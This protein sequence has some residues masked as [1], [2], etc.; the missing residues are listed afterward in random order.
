MSQRL[1]GCSGVPTEKDPVLELPREATSV[2]DSG[3]VAKAKWM[4][5]VGETAFVSRKSGTKVEARVSVRPSINVFALN[6]TL[7]DFA[8][9]NSGACDAAEAMFPLINM[10]PTSVPANPIIE[11]RIPI[12]LSTYA[13]SSSALTCAYAP[14]PH[15][16]HLTADAINQARAISIPQQRP[17]LCSRVVTAECQLMLKYLLEIRTYDLPTS[18]IRAALLHHDSSAAARVCIKTGRK[19]ETAFCD[20]LRRTRMRRVFS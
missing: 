6:N 9:V 1:G 20:S 14:R 15:D 17:R 2:G 7:S 12:S 8:L 10:Q 3:A 16:S 4:R 13:H 5:S 19:R 18:S 11:R